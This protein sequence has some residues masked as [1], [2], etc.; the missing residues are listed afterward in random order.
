MSNTSGAVGSFLDVEGTLTHVIDRGQG[1][2]IVLLHGA[3]FGTDAQ[4]TWMYQIEELAAH[5][6]VIAIDQLGFGY[7]GLASGGRYLNRMERAPHVLATLRKLGIS[8]VTLV[9]HSEGSFTATYIA[10]QNPELVSRLILLTTGGTA[11]RFHDERD[12]PWKEASRRLYDYETG[13]PSEEQYLRGV[14]RLLRRWDKR[15]EEEFKRAYA[16]AVEIGQYQMFS[17]AP[18]EELDYD[19]YTR[20]QETH[21]HPFLKSLGVPTLLIWS[22]E[23]ATVPVSRGLLLY[24]MI[25]H[26]DMAI[27]DGTAHALM[28]DRPDSVNQLILSWRPPD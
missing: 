11:P 4:S 18:P 13:E 5:H 12:E 27:L 22:R 28:L 8:D 17:G 14:K 10:L 23:D 9:G 2:S 6:R 16:R 26:A 7:T 1:P 20:L 25:P 3:S 21:I 15:L 24:D 19:L